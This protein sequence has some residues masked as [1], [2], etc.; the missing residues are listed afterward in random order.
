MRGAVKCVALVLLVGSVAAPSS[1]ADPTA[2][3]GYRVLA[4]DREHVAIVSRGGEIE[5]SIECAHISHDIAILD[6]GNLLLHTGPAKVV[7]VTP[8]KQV[9]WQYEG[10]P[11][12]PYTGRVE[13]HA[14]QRLPGGFTMVAESG[15]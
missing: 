6:N 8:T 12:P 11:K 4:Q 13:I 2:A 7:E 10:K 9:V 15:N 1:A 14:F 3:R 5:W